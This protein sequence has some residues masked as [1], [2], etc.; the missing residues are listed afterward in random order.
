KLARAV[1]QPI[2]VRRT[3]DESGRNAWAGRQAVGGQSR[4]ELP[5]CRHL[6]QT[7]ANRKFT[8]VGRIHEQLSKVQECM[9]R[10]E[11]C[12]E[13]S[14]LVDHDVVIDHHPACFRMKLPRGLID[15]MKRKALARLSGSPN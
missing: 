1:Y 10:V 2:V 5:L 8:S 12:A 14:R 7:D 11:L 9:M 15:L 6:L 13:R 3:H 4:R